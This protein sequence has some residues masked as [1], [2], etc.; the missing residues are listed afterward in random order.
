MKRLGQN[1]IYE[2][3]KQD[4][5]LAIPPCSV[6]LNR[7]SGV[8]LGCGILVF[9]SIK[10]IRE[11]QV[12]SVVAD[13]AILWTVACQIPLSMGIRQARII[14][15]VAISFTRESSRPRDRMHFT[16]VS[17]V[18][19]Q[20]LLPLAS[21]RKPLN[22]CRE[23]FISHSDSRILVLNGLA[24]NAVCNHCLAWGIAPCFIGDFIAQQS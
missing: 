6:W 7:H 8:M 21:P 10:Q 12:S 13:S 20:T 9:G 16:C 23:H 22:K 3:K 14:E 17:S 4:Q 5:W 15:W 11:C 2:N 18:G 1:F 24:K 19:R